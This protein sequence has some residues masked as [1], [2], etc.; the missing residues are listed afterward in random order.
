MARSTHLRYI[1][2]ILC[3]GVANLP[4]QQAE[5]IPPPIPSVLPP[6]PPDPDT[7]ILCLR[8]VSAQESRKHSNA[9]QRATERADD[10]SLKRLR[11]L[12]KKPG[13]D[14]VSYILAKSKDGYSRATRAS[15]SVG[16]SC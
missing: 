2:L 13:L 1:L 7:L 8:P 6:E 10:P 5:M 9:L 3:L 14:K 15:Q 16:R 12:L 4:A 11:T